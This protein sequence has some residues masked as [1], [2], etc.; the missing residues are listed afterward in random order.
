MYN[1]S[2]QITEKVHKVTKHSKEATKYSN[3]TSLHCSKT[4]NLPLPT[5]I[6]YNSDKLPELT[7]NRI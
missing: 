2:E 3:V 4:L 5:L 7:N 1:L 6:Q